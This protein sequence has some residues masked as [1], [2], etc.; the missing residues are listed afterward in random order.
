MAE[1]RGVKLFIQTGD[2]RDIDR[3]KLGDLTREIEWDT[4]LEEDFAR[5]QI[6]NRRALITNQRI[7]QT[8]IARKW[9]RRAKYSP[10]RHDDA[11]TA[12]VCALHRRAHTRCK[13]LLLGT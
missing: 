8:Q 3:R 1:T 2:Q 7:I 6:A 11:H 13:G 5:S 10:C 9:L 4:F 12:R